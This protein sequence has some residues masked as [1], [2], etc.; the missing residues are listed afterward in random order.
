M[1]S[2]PVGGSQRAQK[3]HSDWYWP[4]PVASLPLL[5]EKV[6][7]LGANADLLAFVLIGQS[8]SQICFTGKY[9]SPA[10]NVLMLSVLFSHYIPNC[11]KY[12]TEEWFF[13]LVVFKSGL[14]KLSTQVNMCVHVCL[15]A[16]GCGSVCLCVCGSVG[17]CACAWSVYVHA[18]AS[19]EV[20]MC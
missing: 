18:C 17:E 15:C 3:G 4:L 9:A 1:H 19:V 10:T 7:P 6:P 13:M 11:Y 8:P 14:F 20:W 2:S 12:T 5:S 16:H